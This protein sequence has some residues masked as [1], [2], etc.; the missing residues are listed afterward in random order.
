M[1]RVLF[2]SIC[3]C[4]GLG[5]AGPAMAQ[6]LAPRDA[7]SA[8]VVR[9]AA[10]G[11]LTSPST[12]P[13]GSIVSDFM[14]SRGAA[15]ATAASLR[16]VSE[17]RDAAT[18][19]TQLRMEQ[20]VGGLQVYGSYVRAMF[21]DR[22]EL[23]HLIENAADV[24]P[25]GV[26]PSRVDA[27]QAL[28]AALRELYPGNSFNPAQSARDG[29]ATSFDA[30]AFF[31]R[32]PT[33]TAMALPM[34]DR[35]LRAGYVV[36]TWSRDGN[37]LNH[38]VVGGDGR[39]LFVESRTNQDSYRVFKVNP[40]APGG[41]TVESG[42]VP[43]STQF[44]P[45]GWLDLTDQTTQYIKGNNARAYLDANNNNS[46]DGG[47]TPVADGSFL[48][49]ADLTQSPTTAGNRNVA[50]QNLFY[51][52]NVMHDRLYTLGFDEAAGNFQVKNFGNGGAGN[53]PVNAEAQDGGGTDNAN[54][55]TPTDGS[56]PRM[57]MYLWTGLGDHEVQVDGGANY[58]AAGAS[59]G[60]ALSTTG[61]TGAL[62][63]GAGT[64]CTALSANSLTGKIA[65]VDR[66][67]CDFTVKVKNAQAAGAV[68]VIVANNQGDG[69]FTM[70]GSDRKVKIPS[71][72][73]G[74]SS[75]A[76]LKTA[77]QA[78]QTATTRKAAQAPLQRD[79]SVDSDIVFHEYCHGLT[80]RMI[81]SMSGPLSGAIGEGMSDVCS[82]L[83][84]GDSMVGEYSASDPNGIRRAPY[85]GYHV[86]T[87]KDIVGTEVH[88]D[89][90]LYGAIGWRLKENFE[91]K[92]S[93]VDTLFNYLVQGMNYTSSGPAFE[94]MRDGILDAIDASSASN[95]A[96]QACWVWDAFADFGV[97]VNADA[98]LVLKRGKVAVSVT[99][100]LN[101]P[102]SC[103]RIN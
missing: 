24:T 39:V 78:A 31:Y 47:G 101:G 52:N 92:N 95:K 65:I 37:E 73:V 42:P 38:T 94:D 70:G 58:L 13:H 64:A 77:A 14:Q 87:Y 43:G 49:A 34:T 7:S 85:A 20:Q 82:I 53:D 79:G 32:N 80:W 28:G 35:V 23:V 40:D 61:I 71:V 72:M 36:E 4:A 8:R 62:A 99:E 50:V 30:G 9:A 96:D 63:T 25:A 45:D 15:P 51:L 75:G 59:F 55:S 46:P 16:A 48:T 103:L 69:Y 76:A 54:F 56:A 44:S 83:M 57:Q 84:N 12:A 88:Q 66:G 91:S 93:N 6:D 90:E 26:V 11:I 41:Q 21:S 100:D 33:V 1:K 19:L 3:V 27:A 81:G 102:P 89:G 68:A 18:G 86:I 97:G 74:E 5:T 17:R 60:P 22:G 2:A 29:N 98:K 67:T 10:G